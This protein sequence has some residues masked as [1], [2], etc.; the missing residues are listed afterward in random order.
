MS[1]KNIIIRKS[2]L[3]FALAMEKKL[4]KHDDAR[5]KRGW[6]GD[7][8]RSLFIRIKQEITE[9]EKVF[10]AP[11]KIRSA[12]DELNIFTGTMLNGIINKQYYTRTM[13]ECADVANFA[14]MIFDNAQR[15]LED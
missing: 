9:L 3:E 11:Q 10:D 5:G 14:M 2:V 4:Q 7:T 6:D 12:L 15:A 13:D 1:E 8:P